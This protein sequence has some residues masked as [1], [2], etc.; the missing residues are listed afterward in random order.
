MASSQRKGSVDD[1]SVEGAPQLQPSL[2]CGKNLMPRGPL[3]SN[4]DEAF[5]KIRSKS[6]SNSDPP[7]KDLKEGSSRS[8]N[9][10]KKL[11]GSALGNQSAEETT[12]Q[13]QDGAEAATS[14]VTGRSL[15]DSYGVSTNLVHPEEMGMSLPEQTD[16]ELLDETY[17]TLDNIEQCADHPI[18][19]SG[20]PPRD[21]VE[22][23]LGFRGEETHRHGITLRGHQAGPPPSDLPQS[24]YMDSPLSRRRSRSMVELNQGSSS[25]AGST[26]SNSQH[27]LDAEAQVDN[28]QQARKPFFPSPLHLP[29]KRVKHTVKLE[30]NDDFFSARSSS[31]DLTT[32]SSVNPFKYDAQQYQTSFK[33]IKERDVSQALRRISNI[34]DS[35]AMMGTPEASA[36]AIEY[37]GPASSSN[38]DYPITSDRKVIDVKVIIGDRAKLG[39]Q[40]DGPSDAIKRSTT[41]IRVGGLLHNPFPRESTG[42]GDW[43]TETTGEVGVEYGEQ[44]SHWPTAIQ[45]TGSSIADYSDG[46]RKSS[47]LF[48]SKFRVLQHPAGNDNPES[49][50][51]RNLKGSRQQVFLPKT[52]GPLTENS[53]RLFSAGTREYPAPNQMRQPRSRKL[54]NPFGGGDS[55]RR[56][57]PEGN[58]FLK[59]N[60][61]GRSKYEFRDSTTSDYVQ[62]IRHSDALGT[63][64]SE[65][66]MED[67]TTNSLGDDSLEVEPADSLKQERTSS[68]Q[69]EVTPE[70]QSEIRFVDKCYP[71][72]N[73]AWWRA[74]KEE[75]RL[76]A[77]PSATFNGEP[78]SSQSKFAFELLPLD[79]ARRRE[80]KQ[81]ENGEKDETEPAKVRFQR[82]MSSTSSGGLTMTPP[83]VRV[84]IPERRGV[85]APH[86]SI[87]FSASLDHSYREALQDLSSPFS[88]TSRPNLTPISSRVTKS[89][90]T[91]SSP[92]V[93]V[94]T[95]TPAEKKRLL[96]RIK[97]R[98]FASK[99]QGSRNVPNATMIHQQAV[100]QSGLSLAAMEELVEPGI[101]A[102]A[103][104]KRRRWFVF[105]TVLG[106]IFPFVAIAVIAGKLNS[107]L[108]WY[109][110][111]E[112][113]NLT[114]RQRN[115]IRNVFLFQCCLY[116]IIFSCVIAVFTKTST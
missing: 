111:G 2:D 34:G 116:T 19:G 28:I 49:Y 92:T 11:L 105:V 36:S 109:T 18:T 75:A 22:T 40:E 44:I 62:A 58:F 112:V 82:A 72:R 80:K 65:P 89:I 52:K 88:A 7:Q 46:E 27:L 57:D 23:R 59:G 102:A 68:Q 20:V 6:A 114:I 32:C 98:L 97:A 115:F 53:N 33:L 103:H 41:S 76:A 54:S 87:N 47:G 50:E 113:H 21:G 5:R 95:T 106:I 100:N 24:P 71:V 1:Q 73:G 91:K 86:L 17:D 69:V 8:E 81:R 63:L 13:S 48:G 90:L 45:K 84:R 67:I 43:V 79:E 31:H 37:Q 110:N 64:T 9:S 94:E 35:V 70:K 4:L 16:V 99:N 38:D 101:P 29:E 83:A 93:T 30:D 74:E 25:F 42:D 77:S 108:Q 107:S 85:V 61:F 96:G 104:K 60:R 3:F 26:V 51:L 66:E 56:A 14:S 10:Q 78:I 12:A 55:Y 39:A 15:T